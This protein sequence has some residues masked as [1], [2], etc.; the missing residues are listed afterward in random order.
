MQMAAL[1]HIPSKD[2]WDP[3]QVTVD[4]MSHPNFPKVSISTPA[5]NIDDNP[6]S[7][8]AG[9]NSPFDE[10]QAPTPITNADN[11]GIYW[12]YAQKPLHEPLQ[13]ISTNTSF[14]PQSN[15]NSQPGTAPNQGPIHMD[16]Q[17]T[18]TPY[19]HTFSSPSAAMVMLAHY[20]GASVQSL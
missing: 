10:A 19:Y 1:A 4:S 13:Q 14:K 5:T 8:A 7:H 18:D 2:N 16:M 15:T 3:P 6:I 11:F 9:N 12:V 20:T 17:M